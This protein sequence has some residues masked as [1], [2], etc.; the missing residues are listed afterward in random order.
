M[1]FTEKVN[2]KNARWLLASLSDD[3]LKQHVL[4]GEEERFNFSYVKKTLQLY[5]DGTRKATYSKKDKFG[6]LRD[7][8]QGIQTFPTIFRGLLCKEMTDVDMVN[9]H[10]VILWNL[11]LKHQLSC[12]YLTDYIQNRNTILGHCSKLDIIRSINKKQPLKCEGWL[13]SFDNEMKQLQKQFFKMPEYE[14]QR[15][16]SETNPRNREGSFMS[17]LA[18]TYEAIILHAVLPTNLEIGVL[19]YDGFMFY[20]DKPDGLLEDLSRKAKA[21]GFD[22]QFSYKEHNHT[23]VVPDDWKDQDETLYPLLKEKYEKDYKLAYI[24]KDVMYSYKIGEKIYFFNQGDCSQHFT[25]VLIGKQSFFVLW[26]KD[27]TKQTYRTVGSYPHDVP[28]PDGVL[29]LWT[30]YAAEKLPESDA[31]ITPILNHFHTLLGKDTE[32]IL[33]WFANM[34][35]FPSSRSLLIVIQGEEGCGKSVLMDFVSAIMG[36]DLAIEIQDVKED[37]FGRFN[38]ILAGKVFL[39]INETSRHE[40]MPFIEKLKT[41]ITSPTINIEEK[42]QK[43]YTEQNLSHLVMTVNPEN[44]IAIKEGSRRFFYSRA[45]P[46]LIG[47]TDYFNELFDY[48]KQ[49]KNQRAFYQ[50]LMSRPVKQSI[51]IKDIPESAV[52]KE[53]YELNKDPVEDYLAEF[54][55]ERTSQENYNAYRSFL[56][57]NGLK[58]EVSKKAFETKFGQL[59]AKYGVE[60]TQHMEK[61]VRFYKF[62]VAPQ[63]EAGLPTLPSLA[64]P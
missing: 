34:F 56:M 22:I 13:K 5:K 32:F 48:I 1:E 12:H 16:L 20:G 33:D 23:L 52:M 21:I 59:K 36:R 29:N 15:I 46:T 11:C 40:M 62:T 2:A 55:G 30:G 60:R 50:F 31:D 3:F 44:V 9:A 17:H 41:I 58:F 19:M 27:P 39:N 18:T 49:P 51:T 53:M 26:N 45:S 6:I 57:N 24:E 10:P 63:L 47:N 43:K 38:G 61:G 14:K 28:C 35:Q 25:N 42:G 64:P 4:E 54:E 37:L 7:Y 8:A